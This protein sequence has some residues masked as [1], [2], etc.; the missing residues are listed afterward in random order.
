MSLIK[1]NQTVE[2]LSYGP[3]MR[4]FRGIV[5][6][7][8]GGRAVIRHDTEPKLVTVK[9]ERL[10]IVPPGRSRFAGASG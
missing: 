8:H 2:Y 4:A 10:V 5:R 6:D 3:S 7:V 9:C 1:I